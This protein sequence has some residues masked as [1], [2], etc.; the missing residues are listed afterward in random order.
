MTLDLRDQALWARVLAVDETSHEYFAQRE[1]RPG[2]VLFTSARGPAYSLVLI[3]RTTVAAAGP[4]LE[5]I[6]DH[7]AGVDQDTR[8]RVTPLSEPGDWPERLSRRGFVPL[9]AEDELFMALPAAAGEVIAPDCRH[10]SPSSVQIRRVS[11]GAGAKDEAEVFT[12]VQL[13]GFGEPLDGLPDAIQ[14]TRR[15]L[16]AGRYRLYTAYLGNEAAG[17]VSARMVGDAAGGVAGLY[18]LATLP[19]LRR[20]G[21]ALALVRYLVNEAAAEGLDLVYLSAEPDSAGASLYERLGFAPIFSVR[22]YLLRQ[23]RQEKSAEAGG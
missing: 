13:A 23:P 22:N 15:S 14:A 21:V 5:S 16:A 8:V 17:A 19:H 18:G 2:A 11:S 6:I 9:E 12:R 7:Y 10:L 4:M 1:D 20:R 3:T